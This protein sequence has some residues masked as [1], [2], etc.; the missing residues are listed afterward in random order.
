MLSCPISEAQAMTRASVGALL[1]EV[2]GMSCVMMVVGETCSCSG[3]S[4]MTMLASGQP[5]WLTV[6]LSHVVAARRMSMGQS[7]GS[8]SLSWSVGGLSS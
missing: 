5:Y 4:G 3:M 1:D 6:C 8:I 2:P 7:L